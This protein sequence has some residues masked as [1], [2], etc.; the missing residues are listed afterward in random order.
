M[1][2]I[3]MLFYCLCL[4]L[5]SCSLRTGRELDNIE[6]YI[7]EYPDSAMAEL[8][9]LSPKCTG[10][11]VKA[12]QELLL[13]MANDLMFIDDTEDSVIYD[14]VQYYTRHGDSRHAMLSLYYYGRIRQNGGDIAGASVA[15][16]RAQEFAQRTGD[17]F[18]VGLITRGLSE[19]YSETYDY[20]S[21]ERVLRESIDAFTKSGHELYA[22]YSR[23][24][25]AEAL[26]S[27]GK[28]RECRDLYERLMESDEPENLRLGAARHYIHVLLMSTPPEAEESIR[29]FSSIPDEFLGI[30]EYLSAAKAYN[31]LEKKDSSLK[32]LRLAEGE[33]ESVEDSIKVEYA[34]YL[35]CKRNRDYKAAEEHLFAAAEKQDKLLNVKLQN[36]INFAQ[37]EYYKSQL[38]IRAAEKKTGR[39]LISV[40][41]FILLLLVAA[42]VAVVVNKRKKVR[43]DMAMIARISEDLDRLSSDNAEMARRLLEKDI[44]LLASLSSEYFDCDDNQRKNLVFDKFQNA[45]GEF[46]RKDKFVEI[47][48]YLKIQCRP[49]Q[50]QLTIISNQ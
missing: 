27:E 45:I 22:D 14:A 24:F 8:L 21:A 32:Y 25:L 3:L 39:I 44:S 10:G 30:D 5:S 19:L 4:G 20:A 12:Q 23:L 17:K 40:Q 15:F 13:T 48:E 1:K 31:I 47:E 9:S 41:A 18:Y 2:R 28:I 46:R 49:F 35:S 43:E 16:C 36:H 26:Q 6:N 37:N 29:I 34:K 42:I 38:Q 7:R 33:M 11:K 50:K